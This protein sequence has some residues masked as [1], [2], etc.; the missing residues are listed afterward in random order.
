M[1]NVGAYEYVYLTCDSMVH[2]TLPLYRMQ[3]DGE[4]HINQSGH[5]MNSL[6]INRNAN[7]NIQ[8]IY[9]LCGF[10]VF[11]GQLFWNRAV[12]VSFIFWIVMA[13]L[14]LLNVQFELLIMY[15]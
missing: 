4:N 9:V 13:I 7:F 15:L 1:S 14:F 11:I 2:L 8:I 10:W 12:R 3:T 6:K 5:G